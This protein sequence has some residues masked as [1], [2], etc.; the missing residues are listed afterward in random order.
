MQ[1][2]NQLFFLHFAGGNC[3]SYNYLLPHLAGLEIHQLELSGRGK[4]ISEGFLP[5][6]E[7]AA[8]DYCKQIQNLRN[9]APFV[10]FGHSM[11]ASLGHEMVALL[12]EKAILPKRLIV[13]GNPGPNIKDPKTRHLLEKDAFI[14]ELKDIGG[15]P[16]SF[17]EHEDL[18]E[19]FLPMLKADFKVVE[20]E[21]RADY[22]IIQTPITAIMGAE[23]DNVESIENWKSYTKGDFDSLVL[24]GN[25]FF[26]H[27]HPEKLASVI[28]ASFRN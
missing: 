15:M 25:H 26:I 28:T 22:P 7:A 6:R 12:E 19:F 4:R 20:I 21:K 1:H 24:S 10:I 11:G 8:E 23:E 18:M 14:A 27:D 17:F 2:K 13:S 16:E 3:Y 9:G 5:D